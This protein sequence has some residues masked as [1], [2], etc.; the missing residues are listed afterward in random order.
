MKSTFPLDIPRPHI[1]S[2]GVLAA[3][4][5]DQNVEFCRTRNVELVEREMR[6]L[7]DGD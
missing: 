1:A 7:D 5:V 4:G 2:S 3:E 6:K